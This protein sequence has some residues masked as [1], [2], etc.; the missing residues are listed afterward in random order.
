ME[1]TAA[2]G[3]TD[4][5]EEIGR[6]THQTVLSKENRDYY[7]TLEQDIRDKWDEIGSHGFRIKKDGKGFAAF[8]PGTSFNFGPFESFLPM[9]F[10][11]KAALPDVIAA[12][13]V[14]EEESV[15][16]EAESASCPLCGGDVDPDFMEIDSTGQRYLPELAPTIDEKHI[17]MAKA[18]QR[19]YLFIQEIQKLE[20]KRDAETE[21]ID[22]LMHKFMDDLITTKKGEKVFPVGDIEGVLV[23]SVTEKVH[24][25]KRTV[26]EDE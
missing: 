25:R 18:I 23:S 6:G 15:E 21:L 16:P 9:Y 4:Q 3:A 8:K 13:P 19:R 11:V 10:A 24:T 26:K 20:K 5:A 17:P 14:E 2:T 22:G 12:E 1:S 7:D